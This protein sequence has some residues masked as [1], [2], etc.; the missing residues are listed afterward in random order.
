MLTQVV[1]L[2]PTKKTWENVFLLRFPGL[3][4]HQGLPFSLKS[5]AYGAGMTHL[6]HKRILLDQCG[7]EQQH[8]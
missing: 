7:Y 4:S 3:G 2:F 8:H 1:H 5:G 6:K